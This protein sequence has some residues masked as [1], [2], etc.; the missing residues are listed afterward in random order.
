MD[1]FYS[2]VIKSI[3]RAHIQSKPFKLIIFQDQ[4]LADS[5]QITLHL[6]TSIPIFSLDFNQAFSQHHKCNNNH[7]NRSNHNLQVSNFL[8]IAIFLTLLIFS[9]FAAPQVL[10]RSSPLCIYPQSMPQQVSLGQS[11]FVPQQFVG[12]VANNNAANRK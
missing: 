8:M 10:Y 7:N 5:L 3:D 4:H 2:F 11:L 12:P 9:I 6:I 1:K